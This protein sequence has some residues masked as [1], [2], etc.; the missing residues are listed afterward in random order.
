MNNMGSVWIM[1]IDPGQQS[2]CALYNTATK[3]LVH[4]WTTDFWG[5]YEY[6]LNNRLVL[7]G[8]V[9]EVPDSKTVYHKPS[10]SLAATQRTAVN[11]GGVLREA[12]LLFDG[13]QKSGIPVQRVNP[14]GKVN[15]E[16]FKQLTGWEGRSNN[17]ERDA[18]MLTYRWRD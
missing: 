8:V 10:T 3:Q 7:I 11:V 17:H 9:V 1:G 16:K 15:A 4:L 6:V 5:A 2:G 12:Q 14:R 13:I 18:G